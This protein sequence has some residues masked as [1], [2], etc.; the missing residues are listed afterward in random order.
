M[1]RVHSC[2]AGLLLAVGTGAWAGGGLYPPLAVDDGVVTKTRAEVTA[3]LQEAIRS[4]K[5]Y[6][7]LFT[8]EDKQALA[9]ERRQAGIAAQAAGQPAGFDPGDVVIVWGDARLMRTKI[10][11][12]AA[13]ANRLG[14]LAFGE[15][16]PPVATAEQEALIAAAGRRA[17]ESYWI[18]G[19][20]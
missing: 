3:E 8:Y 12:E 11:A 10:Q 20:L 15:G 13:E 17:I 1:R 19:S 6:D 2:A 4:G 14:L 16:D 9:E 5:M 7:Q 18:V